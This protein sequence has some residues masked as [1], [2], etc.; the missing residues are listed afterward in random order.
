MRNH[1]IQIYLENDYLV[2]EK[3]ISIDDALN[4]YEAFQKNSLIVIQAIKQINEKR[5]TID[6]VKK[7]KN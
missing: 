6:V 2:T 5:Y 7:F 1:V 4:A 3:S